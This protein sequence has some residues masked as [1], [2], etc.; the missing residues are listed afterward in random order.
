M[1]DNQRLPPL[2]HG[3]SGD[4]DHDAEDSG[5]ETVLH[6]HRALVVEDSDE[7]SGIIERALE[8][9]DLIVF[10][11]THGQKAL[12]VYDHVKPDVVLLDISLPDMSGWKVMDTIK[13][14]KTAFRRPAIVI[15]TAYG[16]PAN[17]LMG[18]LRDID[19]YLIK[20]FSAEEVQQ[21]VLRAL[22]RPPRNR[23][24]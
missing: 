13:E 8:N 9:I 20:P 14:M 3:A 16:D 17:R 24:R 6:I 12:D 2:E 23:G 11:E 10:R 22:G 15:I 21:S 19:G 1:S 18:K 7:L 5:A 4:P